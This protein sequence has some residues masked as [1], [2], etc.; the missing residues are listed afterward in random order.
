MEG[1]TSEQPASRARASSRQL[2]QVHDTLREQLETI[3][4]WLDGDRTGVDGRPVGP[5]VDPARDLLTYCHGFC[6]ALTAHH[7]GEDSGLFVALR[8][9]RPDLGAVI[10][11]LVEDHQLIATILE[12]VKALV[13]EA[14]GA[15][16]ARREAIGGELDGL[17]AIMESHFRFEER[18]IGAALDGLPDDAWE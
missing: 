7:E 12:R 1:P 2:A 9:A 5:A 16:T 18:R 8:A 6:R 14:P 3:R 15:D 10:A 17:S 13:D 4:Y 11:K